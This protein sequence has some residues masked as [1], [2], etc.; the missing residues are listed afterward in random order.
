MPPQALGTAQLPTDLPFQTQLVLALLLWSFVCTECADLSV[1]VADLVH[2]KSNLVNSA[3]LMRN[4]FPSSFHSLT[5]PMTCM[6]HGFYVCQAKRSICNVA[7][8]TLDVLLDHAGLR[9]YLRSSRDNY[10]L[11]APHDAA[12]T[13]ALFKES[14]D[15]TSDFYVT[16]PCSSI[17]DVL[18]ATNLRQIL[19][20][21]GERHVF[22]LTSCMHGSVIVCS[23]PCKSFALLCMYVCM[24]ACMHG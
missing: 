9:D 11:F 4:L 6:C 23:L 17:Q 19:L 24:H 2:T 14:L 7:Q 22:N 18:S 21:H 15:C 5:H 3:P 16:S 1:T 8:T 10:T 12:W 20:S 13:A